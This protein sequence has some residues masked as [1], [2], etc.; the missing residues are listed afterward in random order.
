M[1]DNQK[2]QEK[3][4]L[5]WNL[6]EELS[7]FLWERYEQE[8]I[9]RHLAEEDERQHIMSDAPNNDLLPF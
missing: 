9:E 6:L 7:S 4:W 8:F 3:A 5:L 1:H 2:E